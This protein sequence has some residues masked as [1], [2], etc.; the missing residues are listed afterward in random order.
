MPRVKPT[1]YFQ[2]WVNWSKIAH[3]T[4][5]LHLYF[6][7]IETHQTQENPPN[8]R[9]FFWGGGARKKVDP[10]PAYSTM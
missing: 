4:G 2:L 1:L 9:L 5:G 10:T 6:G 3:C 7:L 8:L